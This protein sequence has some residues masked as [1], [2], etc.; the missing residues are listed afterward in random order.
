MPCKQASGAE[1]GGLKGASCVEFIKEKQLHAREKKR[2]KKRKGR[3]EIFCPTQWLLGYSWLFRVEA[4]LF[5]WNSSKINLTSF[6]VRCFVTKV[7]QL[8][9]GLPGGKCSPRMEPVPDVLYGQASAMVLLAP[10]AIHGHHA[11]NYCGGNILM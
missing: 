11:A 8:P 1:L 10:R 9:H 2:K 4:V 3:K 7:F 6:L 5:L